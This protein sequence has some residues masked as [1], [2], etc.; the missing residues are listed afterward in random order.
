[1]AESC[2][3]GSMEERAWRQETRES[4]L[5]PPIS[6]C[7]SWEKSLYLPDLQF[8]FIK[9][10]NDFYPDQLPGLLKNLK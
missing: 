3:G 2:L 7:L 10:G 5:A 1:M 6:S 8:H 9:K 4:L